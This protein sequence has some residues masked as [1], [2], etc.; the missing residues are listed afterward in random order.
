MSYN[1]QELTD[2]VK[3]LTERLNEMS[4][5][6]ANLE[7][8]QQ[9]LFNNSNV[10]RLLYDNKV[11]EKQYKLIVDEMNKIRGTLENGGEVNSLEFESKILKIMD[12][13]HDLDY[14]FCEYIAKDFMEQGSWKEVFP[15]LYGYKN[16]N[17]HRNE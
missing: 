9:C 12:N 16:L 14:H 3:D 10:D 5:K 8:W 11:T 13:R 6:V 1:I 17:K 2:K 15:A 4:E 7:F